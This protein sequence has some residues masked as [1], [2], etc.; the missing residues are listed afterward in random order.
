MFTQVRLKHPGSSL[1]HIA[2]FN[3]CRKICHAIFIVIY[4]RR[5][6]GVERVPR[7]GGVLLVANHQSFFDPPFIGGCLTT[8]DTDFLARGGLFKF[9][10]FA[11]II[12][13]LNATPINQG[14]GDTGAMK[15]TIKRLNEG[16]AM[17]VFP[18]GSRTPDGEL[19]SFARGISVLIKR[20]DCVIVPVGIAGVFDVWPRHKKLPRLFTRPVSIVYGH[21][22]SSDELMAD[23]ATQAIEAL[24]EQV[25]ELVEQAETLRSR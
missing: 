9:K 23:G 16:K 13:K 7:T 5:R 1:L 15:E 21:P 20:A 6:V 11:W 24:H 8:R 25:R 4:R 10:P 19:K 18:E 22:I 14:A 12:S 2:F 3:F 17:V